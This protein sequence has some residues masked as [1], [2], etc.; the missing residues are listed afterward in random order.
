MSEWIDLTVY[1]AFVAAVWGWLPSTSPWIAMRIVADRNP[2]WLHDHPEVARQRCGNRW[3]R[4]SC[5]MW[6]ALSLGA[7]LALQVGFWP[8]A[9]SILQT[10]PRWEAL[11]NLNSL[12]LFAGLVYVVACV[13]TFFRWLD[14]NV[15]PASRRY[16]TLER[17]T[18]HDYVPRA[19]QYAVY[20][21]VIFH[22]AAWVA[23]GLTRNEASTAFW[24]AALF[25]VAVAA[26]FLAFARAAV[27]R[28]PG[29]MD[30]ILGPDY[31]RIEVRVAFAAQLLPLAN[32]AA[33]LYETAAVSPADNLDRLLHLG[34]VLLIVLLA[35]CCAV[36]FGKAGDG[37]DGVT[38]GSTVPTSRGAMLGT[39]R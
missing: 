7:L 9:L 21:L 26:V 24:G 38:R 6:G 31:R 27:R 17:R 5:R 37:G 19:A 14:A 2:D 16:A 36:W 10:A 34:L 1:A 8:P 32:G 22:L 23:V 35:A 15:P 30:R 13:V 20:A 4:C 3:F 28:R 18:L 29:A 39:P 11:K 25:Q 12:L 33:R